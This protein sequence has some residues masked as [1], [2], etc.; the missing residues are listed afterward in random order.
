MK[1]LILV[2]GLATLFSCEKEEDNC[3]CYRIVEVQQETI[4]KCLS[5]DQYGKYDCR[6]TY[7]ITYKLISECTKK[8]STKYKTL[9]RID[10]LQKVGDCFNSFVEY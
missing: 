3:G 9:Q 2:L 10:K 6:N 7:Y 5:E 8:P 4:T 1:K